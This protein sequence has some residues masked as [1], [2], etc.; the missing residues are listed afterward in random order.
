MG[1]KYFSYDP[2]LS[3]GVASQCNA[4]NRGPVLASV[5]MLRITK[6]GPR[7][8]VAAAAGLGWA[9]VRPQ[10]LYL[11]DGQFYSKLSRSSQSLSA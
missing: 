6:S 3:K 4:V 11:E 8:G 10:L 5:M 1:N 2:M 7:P 9:R